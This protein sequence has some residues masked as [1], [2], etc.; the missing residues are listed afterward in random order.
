MTVKTHALLFLYP[1]SYRSKFCAKVYI[2]GSKCRSGYKTILIIDT[3]RF[4]LIH[5]IYILDIRIRLTT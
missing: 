2:E 1:Y 5:V 4:H 3:I